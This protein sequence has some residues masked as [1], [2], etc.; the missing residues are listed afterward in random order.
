MSA[1]MDDVLAA[2][3]P[4]EPNYSKIKELGPDC[5]PH[6]QALFRGNDSLLASKAAYAASL[7]PNTEAH[8]LVVDAAQSD[9][10]ALRAAATGGASNLPLPAA[11][12][13]L[14]DLLADRE[15]SVRNKAEAV[16]AADVADRE[17]SGGSTLADLIET[18]KRDRARR[19]GGSGVADVD[20]RKSAS[21]ADLRRGP[22][23]LMPGETGQESSARSA[24]RPISSLGDRRSPVA[25]NEAS[26]SPARGLMPGERAVRR[27]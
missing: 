14:V 4:E 3:G 9:S 25:G 20:D 2:L 12:V 27:T 1:T 5:L 10:P 18:I 23:N 11:A 6:L 24:V 16:V 22:I 21:L 19:G 17:G 15:V 8:D 13:V 26:V 7:L